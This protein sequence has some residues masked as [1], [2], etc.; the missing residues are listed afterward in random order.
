MFHIAVYTEY[1]I[2]FLYYTV[3]NTVHKNFISAILTKNCLSHMENVWG[4]LLKLFNIIL[5][6]FHNLE[7]NCIK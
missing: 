2:V 4:Q 1:Q 6:G 3:A 7:T 5:G